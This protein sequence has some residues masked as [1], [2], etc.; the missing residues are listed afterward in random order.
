MSAEEDESKYKAAFAALLLENPTNP[1]Q[2]A[3]GVF[4]DDTRRA[5]WIATHWLNDPEVRKE[6]DRLR[7]K[8][9]DLDALPSKADLA[10]AAW[11]LTQVGLFEDRIKAMKL[12]ADIRNFIEKPNNAVN[13]NVNQNR[14][15][16]VKDHGS[17]EQW[18][19]ELLKQQHDL[20]HGK[21]VV[22]H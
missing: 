6:V 7:N 17:N 21:H 16:I 2:A 9:A 20:T 18:E 4:P 11:E 22:K 12:Y 3:N 19:S 5:L 1:F 15:M 13:V 10:R 8:G 14:V